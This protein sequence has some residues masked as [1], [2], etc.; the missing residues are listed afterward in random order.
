MAPAAIAAVLIMAAALLL[1]MFDFSFLEGEAEAH[2][3]LPGKEDADLS[4]ES[5]IH[6]ANLAVLEAVTVDRTNIKKLIGAMQRPESYHVVVG[7]TLYH[8]GGQMT[9]GADGYVSEGRYKT[10]IYDMG[11][12]LHSLIYGEDVYIWNQSSTGVYTG[13]AGSFSGDDS[14]WIPTYEKVLALEDAA[15]LSADYALYGDYYCL[16]VE[17]RDPL[18]GNRILYYISVEHGLLVGAQSFEE[19]NLVYALTAEV[20]P[21][22][23]DPNVVFRL[24]DGTIIGA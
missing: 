4:V 11:G 19:E 6:A 20:L 8:S 23:E 17:T 14:L 16:V 5:E 15:I 18:S 10:V 24:P 7:T 1:S 9:T 12:A 21:L 22:T 3:V 13:K 2:I